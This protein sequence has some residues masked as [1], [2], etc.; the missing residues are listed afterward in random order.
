MH[1]VLLRPCMSTLILLL[2]TS[3]YTADNPDDIMLDWRVQQ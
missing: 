1:D 3:Y 2:S